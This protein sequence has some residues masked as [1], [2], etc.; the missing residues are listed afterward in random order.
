MSSKKK[1]IEGKAEAST[2]VIVS[3]DST[4]ENKRKK[5]DVNQDFIIIDV[6]I[7]DASNPSKIPLKSEL[8]QGKIDLVQVLFFGESFIVIYE[9]IAF[10]DLDFYVGKSAKEDVDKEEFKTPG[11]DIASTTPNKRP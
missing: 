5:I 7:C 3:T 10:L 11:Q 6:N 1:T 8:T 4:I 9:K 2:F